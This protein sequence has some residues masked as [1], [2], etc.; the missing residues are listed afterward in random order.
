VVIEAVAEKMEVKQAVLADLARKVPAETLILSNTSSLSIG[1]MASAVVNPGRVA[2]LHFFNP[3]E[4]MPLVEVVSGEE[5]T[6]PT[7]AAATAL[8][9]QLGKIPIPVKDRPGFLVNRLL[10]PY[11]NE[12]ARLLEEGGDLELIDRSARDFGLPLGPFGLLDMVGLDIA[13]HVADTLHQAFG[14]RMTPS[15]LL[16]RMVASGRLGRKSGRGF[17]LYDRGERARFE[18]EI[19]QALQLKTPRESQPNAGEVVDRL[20]LTMLNEAARCLA[21]EVVDEPSALDAALLFGAG[22]P[23]YTG[24]LLRYADDRG[25]AEVVARLEQLAMRGGE[26]YLPAELLRNM[27][28][29]G[30]KFYQ[31]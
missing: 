11:L 26:R 14:G 21:E 29:E 4:R 16:A 22:F 8:A 9:L 24:G 13:A 19:Y 7:R 25:P 17:Y 28:A 3:V 27:A 10:L 30:R 1:A 15:P 6:A 5:T 2:G 23:P 31:G 20:V 12:A 18:A